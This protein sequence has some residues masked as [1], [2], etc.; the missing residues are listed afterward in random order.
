MTYALRWRVIGSVN[1]QQEISVGE[2]GAMLMHH[3]AHIC[4]GNTC[5]IHAPS[6]HAL[7]LRP[8]RWNG[9]AYLMERLCDH[10][11]WHADRDDQS[12][13]LGNVQCNCECQ[14][15]AA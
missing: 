1:E 11:I 7:S 14:C 13:R 8:V 12:V 6:D 9:R 5:P 3:A 2:D 10:I 15:C 4:G